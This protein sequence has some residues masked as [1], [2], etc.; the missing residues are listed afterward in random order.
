MKILNCDIMFCKN[1]PDDYHCCVQ[2]SE[3]PLTAY[4]EEVP[5]FKRY[6]NISKL[7]LRNIFKNLRQFDTLQEII[8]SQH[9]HGRFRMR[10]VRYVYVLS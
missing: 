5:T 4:D 3:S 10:K 1:E 8:V 7:E 6:H 9:K 2:W